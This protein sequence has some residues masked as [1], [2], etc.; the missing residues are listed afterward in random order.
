[1]N[2]L[3]NATEK[4]WKPKS[5][6]GA[7]VLR[8]ATSGDVCYPESDISSQGLSTRGVS[9]ILHIFAG[10]YDQYGQLMA[11]HARSVPFEVKS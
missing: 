10:N 8:V 1:M 9:M 5:K 6:I 2:I 11:E 4:L 3:Y 7:E